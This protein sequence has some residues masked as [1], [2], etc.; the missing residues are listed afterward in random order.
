MTDINKIKHLEDILLLNKCEG[1]EYTLY[2]YI[3]ILF[4]MLFVFPNLEEKVIEML[5]EIM[6][7]ITIFVTKLFV[8]Y[9]IIVKLYNLFTNSYDLQIF[10]I[11]K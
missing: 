10:R 11:R 6:S 9:L 3:L 2:I 4:L 1:F 7:S 5:S 8:V